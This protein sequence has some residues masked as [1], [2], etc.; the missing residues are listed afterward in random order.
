MSKCPIEVQYSHHVEASARI[1][2]ADQVTDFYIMEKLILD[3][4]IS[5]RKTKELSLDI[6]R[7]LN[8]HE[9]FRRRL[10]YFQYP[11]VKAY[12][13][14]FRVFY[15]WLWESIKPQDLTIIPRHPHLAAISDLLGWTGQMWK[16][17]AFKILFLP[18]MRNIKA[19]LGVFTIN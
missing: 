17:L 9:T 12:R 8:V 19:I 7:K 10:I 5:T 18:S 2:R 16:K 4:S 13:I 3:R 11:R 6:R 14:Y 1:C 15:C